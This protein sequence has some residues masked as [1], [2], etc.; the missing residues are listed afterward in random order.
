MS[1]STISALL[2]ASSLSGIELV[3]VS[4]LSSTVTISATTISA[5]ASD[6]S[7]NDSADGFVTAGFEVGQRVRTHGFTGNTANNI[8][9]G[10]ITALTA[11]KM[12]IGGTDGDVIVDDAAGETVTISK[13]ESHRT[14]A[15]AIAR[16]TPFG[17]WVDDITPTQI[18]ANQNN[19]NPTN[20]ATASVVRLSSDAARNITG[21]QGGSDG[22]MLILANVGSFDITFKNEDAAS[23]AANRFKAIGDFILKPE[24]ALQIS[25]DATASRWRFVGAAAAPIASGAALI[26]DTDG[27]LAANS[28]LNVA[29][30]K[31]VKTYV[32]AAV[33][34]LLD[35]K[36]TTNC[37]SDPDYPA[38]SKGDYY[39]VIGSGHIG[40]ASGT[41]VSVGDVYFA[42]ADNAG[43]TQAAVG[44]S[45]DILVHASVAAGGGLLAANNLSDVAN[46]ATSRTNL[47]VGT[48]DSPQFAGVNI[49]HATDTTVA[50]VGAGDIAVEGNLLYRA[51]GTDV[52]VTDGG[53]GA[54]TAAGARTNLGLGTSATQ[55]V[56]TAA[57]FMANTADKM[58]DTDGVWTAAD[59]VALTDAATIAVDMATFINAT[60]T[61]GGNRTLGAPSNTKN[62]Q[63]GVIKIVQDG[64]GSRTL[65]YHAN[66]KF[67]NGAAPVLTTTAG[68]VDLLFYEVIS[69]TFIYATVVKDVK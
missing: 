19:Y 62:Y 6:N 26:A 68:A 50:R 5:Q 9:V 42:V 28:D 3:E 43:G 58:L 17:G 38:A 31:A 13:W 1:T 41:A 52:P 7:Y 55:D 57:E 46:T 35:L 63:T 15:D 30:Q 37:S 24:S 59:G 21:L 69:S 66:W 32:D 18:T 45:W 34:G 12:T 14:T 33:T 25:Y 10:Y 67:A 54:S 16:R 61:L 39:V 65:A 29:T 11:G 8:E 23:T 40:G 64:T 47:G 56:A 2:A 60:V 53:T 44:G 36:G 22:R 49:G 4:Q 20:L 48:G 51:A 27:T